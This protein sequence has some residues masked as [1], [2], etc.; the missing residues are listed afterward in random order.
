MGCVKRRFLDPVPKSAL[1]HGPDVGISFN[2]HKPDRVTTDGYYVYPR[3][4]A[5]EL[6]EEVCHR[7]SRYLNNRLEQDHRGIKQ[8]YYCMRGFKCFQAAFRF[9][10]AFDELRNYL[11]PRQR[12]KQ[13]ISL[14]GQRRVHLAHNRHSVE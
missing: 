11:R 8:R 14:A 12:M 1:S 4:V 6:G 9:C 13:A 5:E 10:Q 2:G 3:A 7:T